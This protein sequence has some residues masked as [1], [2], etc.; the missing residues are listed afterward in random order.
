MTFSKY[1][2][3]V[4]PEIRIVVPGQPV[5]KGRPKAARRR[6]KGGGDY[7]AMITPGKT[8]NYE[9]LVKLVAYQA[10]NGRQL[11]NGAVRL[12]IRLEVSIPSSWSMK[13]Q[14][15]A[16]SKQLFPTTTPDTDNCVKAISD[17]I[18][19]VVW[20]DDKQVV[21]LFVVKRYSLTPCAIVTILELETAA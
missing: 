15:K 11:I 17:A 4:S 18:N 9:N 16:L 1:F 7:I 2:M 5:G 21:E 3:D 20:K 6:K 14:Q 10:M 8:A 13:K 19:G 12:S